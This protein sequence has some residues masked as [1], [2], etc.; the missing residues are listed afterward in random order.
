MDA[1]KAVAEM[2]NSIQDFLATQKELETS[3]KA[4]SETSGADAKEAIATANTAAEKIAGISNQILEI[5]Q[6]MAE[7]VIKGTAKIETLGQMVIGSDAFKQFASGNSNHLRF[8]ANTIIGQEGSPLENA[9]TIV[10]PQRLNGIVPGASRMLRVSDILP[11]GNITSNS[12]EYTRELLFTNNAAE[13]NEGVTKPETVLTFELVT[14]PVKTIAHF[15]KASKQVLDD[16]AQLQSYI[17]TR[18]R[19]GVDVRVDQQLLNGNGTNPNISGILDTGNATAFTPLS[20]ENALDSI[21]RAIEKVHSADYAPT[22]IIMNPADWFA[23][24]RLKVNAGT[25]DR[26]IIGAPSSALSA[27]L[28]GLPVVV[29]NAC[30][31]STFVVAAFDIAYQQ[32]NRTGTVVEAFAQDDTNVQQNLL[33]IRAECRKALAVYRPAS[34]QA[35]ALT[36]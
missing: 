19:Y 14:T 21:N 2:N 26:Y 33:T 22:A 15:I 23:I 18:L 10:A 8:Q 7:N 3:L 31:A 35:G 11:Q 6:G 12:L 32:W 16:A 25:D 1:E 28:W 20:G 36:L 17:D 34:A 9:D 13:T 27:V 5:E 24:E 30:P 4:A 29:T